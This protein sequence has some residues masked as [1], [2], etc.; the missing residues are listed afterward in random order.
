MNKPIT[1]PRTDD[2][3]MN[4]DLCFSQ[5]ISLNP[6]QI[7]RWIMQIKDM[8]QLVSCTTR[9]RNSKGTAVK[10]SVKEG[11]KT[12]CQQDWNTSLPC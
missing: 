12:G 7:I 9:D 8:P 11:S 5:A 2:M 10:L 6:R 4:G 1:R 3:K